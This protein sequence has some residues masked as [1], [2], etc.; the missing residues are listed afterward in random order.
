MKSIGKNPDARRSK[1]ALAAHESDALV[2]YLR[3]VPTVDGAAGKRF[4]VNLTL[5]QIRKLAQSNG[6]W[7]LQSGSPVIAIVYASDVAAADRRRWHARERGTPIWLLNRLRTGV[8]AGIVRDLKVQAGVGMLAQESIDGLRMIGERCSLEADR[9]EKKKPT[10]ERVIR[11]IGSI[12]G[13]VDLADVRAETVVPSPRPES[14]LPQKS[15][16]RPARSKLSIA[17]NKMKGV[18][19][20]IRPVAPRHTISSLLAQTAPFAASVAMN[21]LYVRRALARYVRRRQVTLAM[22]V[23]QQDMD[24]LAAV[25]RDVSQCFPSVAKNIRRIEKTAKA[26]NAAASESAKKS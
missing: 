16:R 25:F 8:M 9:W 19:E 1:L 23:E 12:G 7:A 24:A 17:D 20:P 21:A 4:R 6:E 5:E 14:I 26:A 2:E 11:L 13:P 22:E 10:L 15:A 3:E 18:K